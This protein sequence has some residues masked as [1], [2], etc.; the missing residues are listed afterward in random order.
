M[1]SVLFL[2]YETEWDSDLEAALWED[3]FSDGVFDSF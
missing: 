2:I 1:G 3:S